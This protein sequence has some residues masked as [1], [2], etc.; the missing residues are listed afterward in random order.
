M[1]RQI[2]GA[3]FG[4]MTILAAAGWMRT[5]QPVQ[6][7]AQAIPAL[8]VSQ[9]EQSVAATG[10]H[11]FALPTATSAVRY[12]ADD[13]AP[14]MVL[15]SDRRDR[16]YR[17]NDSRYTSTRSGNSCDRNTSWS[18]NRRYNDDDYRYSSARYNESRYRNDRYNDRYRDYDR[19]DDDR[20][21]ER[22]RSTGKSV[23]I[24]AGSAGAGAAIGAL[25][26]GKKGAAIG[27][28]TGGIGGLV[29]DRLTDNDRRDRRR[30]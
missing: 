25:G 21:Y 27:A 26:G 20:R 17:Y 28:I 1:T 29:Y 19:Y 15:V 12:L 18:D 24:V 23:G 22:G 8:H 10:S 5:P 2:L 6:A 4:L 11:G 16:N 14:R 13:N 7:G 30:R 3:G 9:P